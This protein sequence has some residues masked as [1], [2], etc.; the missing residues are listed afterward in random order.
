MTPFDSYSFWE[1]N[2][3]NLESD[4]LNFIKYVPLCEEHEDVWSFKLVNQL[5]LIGSSIDSFFKCAMYSLKKK[6]IIDH[7]K[8]PKYNFW[9]KKENGEWDC[10]FYQGIGYTLEDFKEES[11][12]YKNLLNDRTPNMG[13]YR[14]LF[15]NYYNLSEKKVYT[16]P[17]KETPR[18]V[19]RVE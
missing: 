8:S 18:T 17:T 1:E 19:Q 11:S 15:N 10:V 14:E 5:V 4:F 2:Y 16:L 6:F 13:L 9:C 7:L 12:F 3:R